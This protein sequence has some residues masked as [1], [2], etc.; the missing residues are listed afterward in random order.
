MFPISINYRNPLE[1]KDN[2]IVLLKH[3]NRVRS[4]FIEVRGRLEYEKV[5]AVM[6]EPFPVLTFFGIRVW[7]HTGL[8]FLP[9]GGFKFLGGS[10]P[11]IQHVL[12]SGIPLADLPIVL[13]SSRDLVC[14]EFDSLD[15]DGYTSPEL[16]AVLSVLT[17]LEMLNMGF[18][19]GGTLFGRWTRYPDSDPPIRAVL[20]A[21]T[22]FDFYGT[23]EYLEDLVAQLDAPLLDNVQV[24]LGSLPS[25]PLPQLSLFI[26]RT[27]NLRPTHA[28]V[29]FSSE[30]VSIKLDQFDR[31]HGGYSPHLS[32][33]T[34]F[35]WSRPMGQVFMPIFVLFPNVGHLSL[36]T[37][38]DDWIYEIDSTEWL[39]SLR[40]FTSL[41]VL[42]FHG[43]LAWQF[44]RTL[45]D[46]SGEA[47]T[48]MLPSLQS[49]LLEDDDGDGRWL[50]ESTRQFASLRQFYGRPVTIMEKPVE[51]FE[52]RR[53]SSRLLV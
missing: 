3:R 12:L 26:A 4:I 34:P 37:S 14:L 11:C 7:G 52:C 53:A 33:S 49:L 36:R 19:L 42:H 24:E 15:A 27:E 25:I 6:K 8:P 22:E 38:V 48:D 41:K 9:T 5:L 35:L 30:E 1:D 18:P 51:R 29:E 10:S 45:K 28:Q 47:V 2:V 21:L 40:I 20:P 46:I 16:V 39:T 13:L 44:T 23:G 50:V 31:T 43:V 32:L 17:R